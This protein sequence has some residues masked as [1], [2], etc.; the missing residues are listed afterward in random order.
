MYPGS[1]HPAL[2]DSALLARLVPLPVEPDPGDR[3][4]RP[5]F[6]T[7]VV[8]KMASKDT[9]ST[10]TLMVW[11]FLLAAGLLWRR[12]VGERLARGYQNVLMS[13]IL[14]KE[15][16]RPSGC[17]AGCPALVGWLDWYP[18]ACRLRRSRRKRPIS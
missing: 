14:V 3:A 12:P 7:I 15:R 13:P 10:P 2:G 9:A 18:V 16:G 8:Y 1:V 5:A 6:L 4:A 11:R 17:S